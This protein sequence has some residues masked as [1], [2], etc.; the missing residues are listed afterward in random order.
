MS[1]LKRI[2]NIGQKKVRSTKKTR[3]F[4]SEVTKSNHAAI[5]LLIAKWLDDEKKRDTLRNK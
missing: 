2:M 4:L 5:A 3:L 1:N